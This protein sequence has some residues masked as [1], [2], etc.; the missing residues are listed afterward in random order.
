MP[1]SKDAAIWNAF[2]DLISPKPMWARFEQL[3]TE[4][5]D[6]RVLSYLL[7][8]R[9]KMLEWIH[10]I[11]V[12][13]DPKLQSCVP[14]LPSFELR[15]AVGGT[16]PEEFL[17]TG[18]VDLATLFELYELHRPGALAAPKTILDFGCGCGRTLRFLSKI[19]GHCRVVGT[20]VNAGLARWCQKHLDGA[21]VHVNDVVPPL[22]NMESGSF[23]FVYS[24][25]IF[26][27]LSES[28]ATAW[29][30]ELGRVLRP[31]GLLVITTHGVHAL[32]V[33]RDS[34][35]HQR[36]F[37]MDSAAV[38]RT[39]ASF[40]QTRFVFNRYE[41]PIIKVANA[42]TNYGL[43]FIHPDYISRQWNNELFEVCT[44]IPA[45]IRGWQ[46][47]VVLRRR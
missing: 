23:D 3:C 39:L 35:V 20:D 29:M 42:G 22:L 13:M 17:W 43:A 26:T 8:N 40:D 38:Q 34:K 1:I 30:L 15:G 24:L 6:V 47:I 7:G 32:E 18:L 37:F 46:D 16:A 33:I 19:E 10:S 14:P 2:L 11:G 44:M 31:G 28:A 41:D 45:G 36:M 21:E 27:H 25:S 5:D 4:R 12:C 9:H